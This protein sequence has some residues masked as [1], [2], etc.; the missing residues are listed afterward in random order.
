MSAGKGHKQ[1]PVNWEKWDAWWERQRQ[2]AQEKDDR[3][4]DIPEAQEGHNGDRG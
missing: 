1:R 4:A 2:K 3:T